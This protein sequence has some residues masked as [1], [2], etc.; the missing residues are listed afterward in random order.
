MPR[1]LLWVVLATHLHFASLYY[2]IPTLPVYA[3]ALG[4]S[5]AQI[6]LINGIFSLTSLLV[7]PLCGAWIDRHGR[8]RFLVAGAVVYVVAA[9]GYFWIRSVPV[10]LGWRAVH[11]LGLASFGTAAASLAG[12]LAPPRR[13]GR[14]MGTFG[15]AQAAALGVGPGIGRALQAAAG[16]RGV[17]LAAAVTAAG[18]LGCSLAVPAAGAPPP[19]ETPAPRAAGDA[20]R[21]R[22]TM[23]AA[24]LGQASASLAYGAVVSFVALVARERAFEGVGAFFLCLALTSLAVRVL[25]GRAY[26]AWGA[27]LVLPPALLAVAAG[28]GLLAGARGPLAFLGAGALIGLGV[29]GTHT[30]LIAHAVDR[31]P[32][33]RRASRV[34]GFTTLWEAGV[35]AGSI[36]TGSLAEALGFPGAFLVLAGAAVVALASAPALRR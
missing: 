10:L 1:T 32:A 21:R 24:V 27:P 26:D 23:G 31:A 17:F 13:R 29:G 18:A 5:S 12:D 6:G 28:L 15:L 8:R 3:Q 19:R 7:R 14:T 16:D 11:A 22:G 20:P 33:G 30:T 36:L 25:A 2:L 34:A 4:G 35:G 9:L